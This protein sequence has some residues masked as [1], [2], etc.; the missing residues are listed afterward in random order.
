MARAMKNS[1]IA[2]IGSIPSNWKIKPLKYSLQIGSGSTPDSKE[3]SYWDGEI[4]WI[5][6]ADYKTKDVFVSVGHSFI[7]EAG[8]KSCSTQLIPADSLIFSKRAPIGSVSISANPL[9]TNQGCL[10][11]IPKQNVDVKYF[12]YL[13][14]IYHEIFELYGAGTTF[15]EIS[16]NSFGNVKMPVPSFEEQK[17]IAF[18]LDTKFSDIIS[19]SSDIQKEIETLEAY[20][21]L[22]ITEAVI[23][24]LN[25]DIDFSPSSIDG[26]KEI[27]SHWKESK[28]NYEAYVRARLGWK[29]LKAE[30][31]VEEGYAF[32]SAFNIQN[33]KL[34][35]E[36][37]N[38][39]TK[40]RYDES[41]E[42]KI[43]VGDVL[44]VKDGAGV[45]KSA[46]VDS[47]P[48][49]KTAP[50]SS[51]GVI[52][53]YSN[54]EYRYLEY[55]LSSSVFSDFVLRLY[56]GMGVPHLTQEVLKTLRLPLPPIA[57]QSEISDFLDS[58]CS[59][60][61]SILSSKK[62]Q[63]EKLTAYKKSLIYAYVTG[64]KEVI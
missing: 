64:K 34:V 48:C 33:N 22:L 16:A 3:P 51:V 8:L 35:W 40:E 61:D 27:P 47:M 55:Y 29:G 25:T 19:I 28:L 38:Y 49:G 56:N 10:W 4:P 7:T 24:G 32:I 63:L 36:P 57:E 23:K 2:W 62:Q 12:Y 58:K 46:R 14:S 45:G 20:K 15:K 41:P 52:T 5:T 17:K 53:P 37:L 13:L 21:K 18:F 43:N 1:G 6:P 44:L 42:I 39:I 11:G 30:E 54:L 26:V 31:Y 9:T 50:N 60:I 59:E